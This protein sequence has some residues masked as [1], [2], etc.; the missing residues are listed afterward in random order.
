MSEE[1]KKFE[2]L[3]KVSKASDGLRKFELIDV[4][5]IGS[6]RFPIEM[7]HAASEGW[8][9]ETEITS[10]G[11]RGL[12][13]GGLRELTDYLQG[14][15]FQLKLEAPYGSASLRTISDWQFSLTRTALNCLSKKK[16]PSIE[17][18]N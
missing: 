2:L 17:T 12:Y 1:K 4:D 13:D 16:W 7:T 6:M 15:G 5:G 11:C 10:F 9:R 3:L 18:G 8:V 14:Q